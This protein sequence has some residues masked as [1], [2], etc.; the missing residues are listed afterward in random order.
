MW[1]KISWRHWSKH[2]TYVFLRKN[3]KAWLTYMAKWVIKRI[4]H[5][6]TVWD[7]IILNSSWKIIKRA[8]DLFNTVLSQQLTPDR[9]YIPQIV[10]ARAFIYGMYHHLVAKIYQNISY[11]GPAVELVLPLLGCI[12]IG[13]F[14]SVDVL[15]F[16]VFIIYFLLWKNKFQLC[17]NVN[18]ISDIWWQ[19]VHISILPRVSVLTLD[20]TTKF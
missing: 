19:P 17:F 4:W 2:C 1:D 5:S 10:R 12:G 18:I 8:S 3:S 11:Y 20:Q 15:S 9:S 16:T 6:L 7:K 13:L 14:L